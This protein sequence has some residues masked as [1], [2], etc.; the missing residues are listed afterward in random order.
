MNSVSRFAAPALWYLGVALAIP[1]AN[2]NYDD[3]AFH[4][5]AAWVLGTAGVT[6]AALWMARS[7]HWTDSRTR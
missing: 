2:G 7:R 5:H 4:G 3:P 6:F 1:F